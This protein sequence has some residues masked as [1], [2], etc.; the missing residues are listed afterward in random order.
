VIRGCVVYGIQLG[1]GCVVC[2]LVC[3]TS[4]GFSSMLLFSVGVFWPQV[5]IVCVCVC[6]CARGLAKLVY[7]QERKNI[8]TNVKECREGKLIWR[9]SL[10]EGR[11][12][13]N[14]LR[15]QSMVSPVVGLQP[16]GSGP[17]CLGMETV[18]PL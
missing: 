4:S 18:I 16:L 7:L 17:A 14:G 15:A 2:G 9:V 13:L 11:I 1:W 3:L 8:L 6:V 10:F 12:P 5:S